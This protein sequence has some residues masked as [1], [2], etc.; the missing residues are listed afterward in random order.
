MIHETIKTLKRNVRSLKERWFPS[1][2]LGELFAAS[3]LEIVDPW[4]W[5]LEWRIMI[6]GNQHAATRWFEA[7]ALPW[8]TPNPGS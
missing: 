8:Q 2:T 1:L 5:A 4:Q 6:Y 3:D 7:N